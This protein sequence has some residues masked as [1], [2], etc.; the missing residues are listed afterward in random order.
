MRPAEAG[1]SAAQRFSRYTEGFSVEA[2]DSLLARAHLIGSYLAPELVQHCL[3]LAKSRDRE[4]ASR[5]AAEVLW[6]RRPSVCPA[7]QLV[8][9]ASLRCR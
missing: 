8:D 2:E 3:H 5:D 4:Q 7:L 1:E 6:V 9:R